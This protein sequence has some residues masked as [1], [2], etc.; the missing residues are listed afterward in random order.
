MD[1][2]LLTSRENPLLK[3]IRLA[4]SEARSSAPEYVVAEGMRAVK[5]AARSG[6]GLEA[7]LMSQTFAAS[8][9]ENAPL[10]AAWLPRNM[11]ICRTTD[12]L[13]K[14]VSRVQSP[15]GILALVRV[16]VLA[17]GEAALPPN[18]LILCAC[19]IQDPGNLGTL[20]R[21]ATAAGASMVCT[22][23]GSVSARNP[24]A[25]RA[26]AGAFFHIPVIERVSAGQL[27]ELG[28]RQNVKLYRTHATAARS[29]LDCDFR[30]ACAVLL[31]NESAGVAADE[32]QGA[33]SISIP[34]TREVESLNVAAAGAII[35]F[36]A[37]R[38]R[39]LTPQQS[40]G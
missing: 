7:V 23:P 22:T 1:P 13:F 35:L 19:G 15:Q 26:S 32:W 36:E 29:Y 9:E 5:E 12:S 6:H 33:V 40:F 34:T 20:V 39:I 18:P 4:A 38:Q 3:S 28:A 14:S 31:G 10:A 16:P 11:R 30:S 8:A 2:T 25:I 17:L 21:T 24:K 37:Y 27:V